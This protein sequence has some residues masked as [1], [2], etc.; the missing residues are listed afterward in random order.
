MRRIPAIAAAAALA[1][2]AGACQKKEKE[3]EHDQPVD[4]PTTDRGASKRKQYPPPPDVAAIPA[5]AQKSPSGVAYKLLDKKGDSNERPG[6]NDTVQVHYTAWKTSGE[7]Y[8]STLDRGKPMSMPLV[9]TGPGWAEVLR[10]MTIG[11]SRR[12]WL[13]P[14]QAFSGRMARAPK[15]LMVYDVEL[16]GI[17]RAPEV[18][19]DVAAP[20]ADAVK[21]PSGLAHKV[22][23]PGPG[24]V[25]PRSFDRVEIHF[26]TWTADGRM[27]DTTRVRKRTRTVSLYKEIPGWIEGIQTMVAGEK[28]RLWM[29]EVLTA[30]LDGRPTV[31]PLVSDIELLSVTPQR[32][33][34]PVPPDVKAPPAG[35]EK[36]AK[37]V[38]LRRLAPGK[39][40]PKPQPGDTVTLN[41]SGWTT[42]G[43]LFDSS[44]VEGKPRS[45]VVGRGIPGWTEALVTM[46]AGEKVRAW[47]PE[48][49]AFRGRPGPQG[50]VV[51]DLELVEVKEAPK[52]PPAPPDVAKPPADAQKTAG[53]VFYKVLQP[54]TGTARPKPTDTVVAHF[55]GWTTDGKLFDSSIPR[56]KPTTFSLMRVIPGWTEAIP[57]MVT[58]Q[59]SRFWIPKELGYPD[60]A[61]GRPHGM[62]VFDV[63]LVEIR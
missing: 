10:M 21:T 32:E 36:T 57:T 44:V 6:P 31:G 50:M 27:V 13:T 30:A 29:P 56:G 7:T 25:H 38:A 16:V 45:F 40:G 1:L 41:Y 5:D 63:E 20:P 11:E 8:F 35:A 60:D 49:L 15:E 47:I 9:N 39:G 18:P 3:P 51:F 37:G 48:T 55:T 42:A 61:A 26:T 22:L 62:L 12:L 17:E 53:G 4:L 2:A 14:E 58:G 52:P 46:T 24:K 23:Q 43:R 28:K 59:K 54:G 19:P 33:P 34:P